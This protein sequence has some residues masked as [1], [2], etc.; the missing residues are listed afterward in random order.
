MADFGGS[1]GNSADHV[2]VAARTGE[3]EFIAVI[4]NA[5]GDP[6]RGQREMH[7]GRRVVRIERQR[8]IVWNVGEG[9]VVGVVEAVYAKPQIE[10]GQR[11]A[12]GGLHADAEGA[13]FHAQSEVVFCVGRYG[14]QHCRNR[15]ESFSDHGDRP[16]CSGRG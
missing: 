15:Q 13:G 3:R 5:G 1:E 11:G 12:P 10:P 14:N 9:T 8:S 4:V 2:G 6:Q 7:I 16:N